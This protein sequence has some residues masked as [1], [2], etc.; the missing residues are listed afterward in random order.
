[1]VGN[2]KFNFGSLMPTTGGTVNNIGGLVTVDGGGNADVVNVDDTGDST[3]SSGTLTDAS[4]TGLGLGAGINYSVVE[5]LNINL[6]SGNDTFNVQ[7]TNAITVTTLNTGSGTNTINVGS[8]TPTLSGGIVDNI[9]GA[10]IIVGSGSDTLNMDD[11]GSTIDKSGTL[12]ATTLTGLGMGGSAGLGNVTATSIFGS[13]NV[14]KAG[15]YG[16]IQTTAGDLGAVTLGAGGSITGITTISAQGAIT[17]QIII[18][19]NLISS[20][21]TNGAFTGVIA[22]QGDIGAIQRDGGGN[23]VTS[24][25]GALGRFGG[26]S[27]KGNDSGKIIALGNLFGD[28]TIGG[29]MT[30]RIAAAGQAVAGLAG[31]RLGILGNVTVKS[32]AAGAAIV[33]GGL[34]GDATG[35]TV[36]SVGSPKGFLAAVGGIN[37][38]GGWTP[39]VGAGVGGAATYLTAQNVPLF[40]FGCHTSYSSTDFTFAYQATAGLKY[41]ISEN[42]ELGIAYKFTGTTDHNWSDNGVTFKTDG[43][44]THAVLASLTWKF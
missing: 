41:A 31:T 24:A 44:V 33:S 27:V 8:L 6:G 10:L 18:R 38:K 3:N 21:K 43:T 1:M 9:Q 12:T 19:G 37:L 23:A 15:I 28:V 34:M 26:I 25:S 17:G 11:T 32:F 4:L 22:A 14:T 40:G 7:S 29:T 42:I 2:D 13:I 20:V 16:I 35:K 39:Y 30:G 5:T 36:I